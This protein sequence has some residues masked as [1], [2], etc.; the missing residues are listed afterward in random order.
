[1]NISATSA[2]AGHTA[3]DEIVELDRETTHALARRVVDAVGDGAR[4]AGDA[5]FADAARTGRVEV[6]VVLIAEA[7]VDRAD[8]GVDRHVILGKVGVD[9]PSVARI[10]MRFLE[11]RH[12]HAPY[13]AA[14]QLASRELRVHQATDAV[15]PH[16]AR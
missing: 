15:G 10:D 14:D 2:A 1:M 8:V 7:D 3:L 5:D 16:D 4:D 11:K 9:N 12:A 13:D 6:R